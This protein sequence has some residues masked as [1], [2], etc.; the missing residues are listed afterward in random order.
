MIEEEYYDPITI[1]TKKTKEYASI[2]RTVS[3][4]TTRDQPFL[5]NL[6]MAI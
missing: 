5:E 4:P 6:K 1:L 3:A 2:Q